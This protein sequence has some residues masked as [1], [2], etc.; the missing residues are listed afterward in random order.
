[1]FQT[2]CDLGDGRTGMW[3]KIQ[4][5][6]FDRLQRK[7]NTARET[8][9]DLMAYGTRHC[10]SEVTVDRRDDQLLP[11]RWWGAPG[12]TVRGCGGSWVAVGRLGGETGGG[13]QRWSEQWRCCHRCGVRRTALGVLD[14][15]QHGAQ[16]CRHRRRPGGPPPTTDDRHVRIGRGAQPVYTR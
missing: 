5:T 12:I 13:C 15:P 7:C 16:Q 10:G 1:M 9:A 6:I 2:L 8:H 11:S 4:R 3:T 14:G